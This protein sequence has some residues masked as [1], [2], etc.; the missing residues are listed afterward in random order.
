VHI[1]ENY[2]RTLAP[3]R[4]IVHPCG[5]K[6]EP[7]TWDPRN[8][9]K[10][11]APEQLVEAIAEQRSIEAFAQLSSYFIPRL[12]SFLGGKNSLESEIDDI[13]QETMLRVWQRA[14]QFNPKKGQVSTWIFTIARNE[15]I[16]RFRKRR[17]QDSST[18][19]TFHL[20]ETQPSADLR[21]ES[22]ETNATLYQAL[23]SLP[24]AQAEVIRLSFLEG[25]AHPQI[26][27]RLDLPLGTV[28][29]RIRLGLARIRFA[30]GIRS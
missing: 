21:I 18:E 22:Q 27:D 20:V 19:D 7:E 1:I 15:R 2:N 29:S 9:R 16:N 10:S 23:C 5:M 11:T 3:F 17:N 24:P 4:F 26:A 30:I 14:E 28:K 25:L 6:S 12:K 13:I 8:V